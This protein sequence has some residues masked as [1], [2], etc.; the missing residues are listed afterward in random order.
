MHSLGI[1]QA[2]RYAVVIVAIGLALFFLTPQP[3]DREQDLITIN[4]KLAGK[5][6]TGY[7][8]GIDL[9]RTGKIEVSDELAMEVYVKRHVISQGQPGSGTA[10]SRFD[11][12]D[13]SARA[14]DAQPD[15]GAGT[16]VAG[17]VRKVRR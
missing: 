11:H 13:L 7:A 1:W 6:Q 14:V 12:G 3:G 5:A 17:V 9:N 15:V 10:I 4:G 8:G 16:V 2:G